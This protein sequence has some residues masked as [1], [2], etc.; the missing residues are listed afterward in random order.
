MRSS[1]SW[2]TAELLLAGAL[3]ACS[4]PAAI[5]P[6]AADNAVDVH[7][8]N[9]QYRDLKDVPSY[10]AKFERESREIY[11]RR[12]EIARAVGLRPG[13]RVA[14]VGAGTG[15]FEPLF[16]LLVGPAGKVHALDVAQPFVEHLERRAFVDALAN[17]EVGRCP[18]DAIGLPDRSLDVVFLCDV[19][20][21]FE[22]PERNLDSI[23]AALAA[24]G[25]LVIVDFE[26]E[27]GR[28]SE[29]V[30]H[31]VRA[32]KA[33]VRAEIERAGFAFEREE[34]LLAENFL[35]VFRKPR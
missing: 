34:R 19:Y 20:H 3:G 16:S 1:R 32:P 10:V 5:A 23:R 29:F 13:D 27:A 9:E 14:D 28:S 25:R 2:R 21:H 33:T 12:V 6:P 17:V 7:A 4:T 22:R 15:I 24:S 26:K 30:M 11:A 35:L 18:E 8:I 31:H